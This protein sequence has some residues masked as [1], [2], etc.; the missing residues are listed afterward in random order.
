MDGNAETK[1]RDMAERSAKIVSLI[2]TVLYCSSLSFRR[3]LEVTSLVC[4][5]LNTKQC[6]LH[7]IKKS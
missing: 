2:R 6:I 4:Y 3:N 7:A 5:L 1:K